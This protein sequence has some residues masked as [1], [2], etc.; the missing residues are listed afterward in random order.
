MNK[1]IVLDFGNQQNE[2]L[3]KVIEEQNI[4]G[5]IL[6]YDARAE[7]IKNFIEMCKNY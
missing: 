6:S 2:D 1:I 3:L 7:A 5:E 4:K